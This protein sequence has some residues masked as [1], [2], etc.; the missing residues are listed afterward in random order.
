MQTQASI[1][2]SLLLGALLAG[3]ANAQIATAQEA[4]LA[5]PDAELSDEFAV[6]VSIDGDTALVGSRFDDDFDPTNVAANSGSAYVFVRS[7][8]TWVF[9]AKLT[10]SDA[11]IVA[12]FG[13][14]VALQGDE[15]AVLAPAETT[16]GAMNGA[17]YLFSR[18]GTTWTETARVTVSD[19]QN[20]TGLSG[21]L[22]F[23][24][25]R[26]AV[27][28]ENFNSSRGCVYVLRR[29]G[30]AWVQEAR[31]SSTDAQQFQG[32]GQSVAL[33]GD[34]L[35]A[36]APDDD[37]LGIDAGAVY[38]FR[39][40][41]TT[42][43]QEA[44]L[45]GSTS[46]TDDLLGTS[47][48]LDGDTL[49]AGAP[50]D[51]DLAQDGGAAF[52]FRRTGTVWS[53]EDVVEGPAAGD[54]FGTSVAL[55]GGRLAV[56]APERVV[57]PAPAAG[58]VHLYERNGA[59]W[60]QSDMLLST[61]GFQSRLG[62]SLSMRTDRL[63]AGAPDEGFRTG[64]AYIHALQGGSANYC[65]GKINSLGC[66]PRVTTTGSPSA[67]STAP[68]LIRAIDVLPG[69]QGLLFY[70][71]QPANL[72]FHG[73]KLCIGTPVVTL[74]PPRIAPPAG[75]GVCPGVLKSNFRKRIQGGAD[76]LLTVGQTVY[77]QWRQRDP[78][79][80]TGFGDSLTDAV[81]FT[82]AP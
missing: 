60:T 35:A 43:S 46:L 80:P 44:K 56:G 70:G 68:F 34:R 24:D 75:S 74:F 77:A 65:T 16:P 41:G 6:S 1:P 79:D 52:I 53:E 19:A 57:P 40:A 8:T 69:E 81:R 33:S 9:Q 15:A 63:L 66:L 73:G 59:T 11:S 54:Q 10:A 62:R 21:P 22:A 50:F 61:G 26:I 30:S 76:P 58:A 71:Y 5:A 4:R 3:T 23:R 32:L 78:A 2:L 31:L 38:V 25:D 45:H 12:H 49:A 51:D 67:T 36:G 47:V 20:F 37:D 39:R 27:G 55:E 17:V 29:Q 7:G 48:A 28:S 18:Q 42:W 72:D 64:A 13:T 82:I 14:S